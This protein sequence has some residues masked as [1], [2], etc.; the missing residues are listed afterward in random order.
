MVGGRSRLLMSGKPTA[1]TGVGEAHGTEEAGND[2]GGT[3]P[4]FWVPRK[5]ERV[6]GL[7]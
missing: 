1:Q 3:G 4:H 7:T 5:R 6:E 2:G